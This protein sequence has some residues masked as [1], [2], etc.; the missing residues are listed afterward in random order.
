VKDLIFMAHWTEII[1]PEFW[2]WTI[3]IWFIQLIS[4]ILIY[5]LL[6][7]RVSNMFL[8]FALFIIPWMGI[9]FLIGY[10]IIKGEE[11]E[12]R[13]SLDETKK[14][15]NKQYENGKITKKDYVKAKKEIDEK[16]ENLD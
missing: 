14:T 8:W 7:K 10:L 13:E 9:L 15:L 12:I 1:F 11:T 3:G 6:K 4:A 5:R 2:Y 16:L